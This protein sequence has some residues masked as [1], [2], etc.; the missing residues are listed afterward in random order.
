[1][2]FL[3]IILAPNLTPPKRRQARRAGPPARLAPHD[4]HHPARPAQLDGGESLEERVK[5]Q[6]GGI[7]RATA[8]ER[9][10]EEAGDAPLELDQ[11]AA[12]RRGELCREFRRGQS[13]LHPDGEQ[14]RM[15]QRESAERE[16]GLDEVGG[17]VV[18]GG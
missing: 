1:M 13:A 17:G 9:C 15:V 3:T 18:G 14:R 16:A 11:R 2:A 12:R 8:E 10:L 6:G 5:L 7:D 4:P